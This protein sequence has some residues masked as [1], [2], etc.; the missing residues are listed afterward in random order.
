MGG[1]GLHF[2]NSQRRNCTPSAFAF[3]GVACDRRDEDPLY[4]FSAAIYT[5][6]GSSDNRA[7]LELFCSDD[8]VVSRVFAEFALRR[9]F[10]SL[11]FTVCDAADI[12]MTTSTASLLVLRKY[13]NTFGSFSFNAM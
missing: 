9:G 13:D 7:T 4:F 2:G 8:W 3:A 11:K 1:C 12:L 10:E 6:N 5:E